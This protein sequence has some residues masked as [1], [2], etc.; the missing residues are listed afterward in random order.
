MMSI[1]PAFSF[2]LA[3]M[4]YLDNTLSYGGKIGR[5]E[6]TEAEASA[7]T[8]DLQAVQEQLDRAQRALT[9]MFQTFRNAKSKSY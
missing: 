1:Q 3:K 8:E 6:M 5:N 7:V 9:D 4:R 2:D